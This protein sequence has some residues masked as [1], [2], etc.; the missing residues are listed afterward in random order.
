MRLWAIPEYAHSLYC[1]ILDHI[2][3][4]LEDVFT[5]SFVMKLSALKILGCKL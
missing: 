1:K 4:A 2:V 3:F 5:N